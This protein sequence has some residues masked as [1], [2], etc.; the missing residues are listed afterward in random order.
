[1]LHTEHI[2]CWRGTSS[3]LPFSILI[4]NTLHLKLSIELRRKE[5]NVLFNDA[6]NT[7]YLRLCGIFHIVKEVHI[8]RED[9]RCRHYMGYSFRIAARFLLYAPSYIQ[10]ST[11]HD[12][13]Y[14][15]SGALA[16]T[17]NSS[18]GSPWRINPTTHRTMNERSY[19]GATSRSQRPSI[20][21]VIKYHLNNLPN[22]NQAHIYNTILNVRT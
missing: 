15:S 12:L 11:Y 19:H 13:C 14:T 20:F 9:T 7:F 2:L 21:K 16:G 5:G 22:Y 4:L 10:D 18:M 8:A 17:R 6:L 1:M 3:N